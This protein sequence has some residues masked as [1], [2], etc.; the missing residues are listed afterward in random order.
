MQSKPMPTREDI[1]A[2]LAMNQEAIR[3]LGVRTLGL[4][5][6]SCRND[7]SVE[8]DLDFVVEFEH[9]SFDGY[10]DLKFF[11]EDLFGRPVDLITRDALK[12]R[13]R[14]P[15]LNDLLHAPGL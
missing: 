13:F 4:F 1:L 10:M 2:T 8:S 12:P 7:A 15:I 11:L 9:K 5:G 3:G 6:S 14:T